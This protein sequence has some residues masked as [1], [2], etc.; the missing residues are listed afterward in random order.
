MATAVAADTAAFEDRLAASLRGF[1]IVG[2]IAI[3]VILAGNLLV[4]PLSAVIVLVWVRWSRTPWRDVGYVRPK[5]WFVEIAA[6]IAS[7]CAFK[8]LMKAIVMPLLGAAPVNQPYHFLAHNPAAIPAP[9]FALIAGAG[10]GEETLFRGFFFERLG[11]LFG[12]SP[13]TKIAI[14]LLTA[15]LFGLAHYAGQGVAGAEQGAIVGLIFRTFFAIKRRIWILMIAHA[16]FDLTAY[17]LIYW[18]VERV[19]AGAVWGQKL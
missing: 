7:G 4:A 12:P 13:F 8:L 17:A 15:A 14:V 10:F 3:A 5:S 18:D 9:L 2:L 19:V 6:G 11:R 1:G 16:A